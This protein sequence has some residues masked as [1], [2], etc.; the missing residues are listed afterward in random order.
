MKSPSKIALAA[1]VGAITSLVATGAGQKI[2]E[3]GGND[4]KWER[5]ACL[6][7]QNDM[8]YS[9]FGS[10]GI[11]C[12]SAR[13]VARKIDKLHQDLIVK[14][15][16]CDDEVAS[17]IRLLRVNCSVVMRFGKENELSLRSSHED[18]DRQM[19][20]AK[21]IMEEMD[22]RIDGNTCK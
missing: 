4:L 2:V 5:D 16:R 3:S 15:G 13:E 9:R 19:G 21:S 12:I 10:F 7:A 6:V 1:G 17:L 11:L 22:L 8:E 18:Y 14:G 20:R